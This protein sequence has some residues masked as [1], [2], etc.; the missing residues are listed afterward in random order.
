MA[1]QTCLQIRYKCPLYWFLFKLA[2]YVITV[3]VQLDNELSVSLWVNESRGLTHSLPVSLQ[4]FN[5]E[6]FREGTRS[7]STNLRMIFLATAEALGL[8]GSRGQAVA[9]TLGIT[10][11]VGIAAF[12]A[13]RWR[14]SQS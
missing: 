12:V 8:Q 13:F 6:D 3:T 1:V 7:T 5:T 14:T 2:L 11:A 9:W 10:S 4:D